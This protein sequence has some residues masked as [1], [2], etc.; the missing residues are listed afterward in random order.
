[1]QLLLT[2]DSLIGQNCLKISTQGCAPSFVYRFHHRYLNSTLL[3]FQL[4][5]YFFCWV[6]L[7]LCFIFY[8]YF[9]LIGTFCSRKK[10]SLL[11]CLQAAGDWFCRIWRSLHD[12]ARQVRSSPDSQL[13]LWTQADSLQSF[14]HNSQKQ[15][16]PPSYIPFT[17][18]HPLPSPLI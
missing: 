6:V 3:S 5:S 4:K 14:V 11:R 16:S 1:M 10:K 7:I 18:N 12:E 2:F 15:L 13:N 17:C 8:F 9:L